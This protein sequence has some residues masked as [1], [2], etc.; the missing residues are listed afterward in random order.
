MKAISSTITKCLMVG[1]KLV[2]A[3]NT[4]VK[5]FQIISVKGYKGKLRT[6]PHAGVGNLVKCR[7]YKGTEKVRH[8]MFNV[9]II[10]Q[11]KEYRRANGIRIRFEDNAGV[12]V[13]DDNEPQGT[14]IKGPTAKEAI[15]RFPLVGKIA[16]QVV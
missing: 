8:Q 12:T 9:V 2:C 13:S 3:D 7:V 15:D 10:R 4:G 14:L 16:G 11:T 5:A 1:S 6:K